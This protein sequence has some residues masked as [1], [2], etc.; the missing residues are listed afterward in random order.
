ML[1][2][3]NISEQQVNVEHLSHLSLGKLNTLSTDLI[4]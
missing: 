1:A 3:W 4:R 2:T